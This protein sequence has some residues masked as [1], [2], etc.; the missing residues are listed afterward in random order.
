[1]AYF[2]V[3]DVN[4]VDTGTAT[5]DAGRSVTARTGNFT[6]MGASAYYPNVMSVLTGNGVAGTAPVAGDVI[7]TSDIHD[8]QNNTSLVYT[9][10]TQGITSVSANDTDVTQP[11]RAGN[12]AKE[13]D[14]RSS[15]GNFLGAMFFSGFSFKQGAEADISV[16]S[17]I[18]D[19]VVYAAKSNQSSFTY[20]SD[21]GSIIS[22]DTKVIFQDAGCSLIRAGG[23]SLF[24]FDNM[25]MEML[26]GTGSITN[27]TNGWFVVGGGKL[28]I[29]NTDLSIVSGTLIA[30]VGANVGG[31]DMIDVRIDN[32]KISTGT[33]FTTEVFASH[34]QR[35]LF[36]RCS[37]V[38]AEAEYQHHLHA[39]GGDVWDDA[40][41]YR[42]ED[43]AFTESNQKISY[44]IETNSDASLGF[45]LWLDFPMSQYVPLSTTSTL[46]FYI[47]CATALTDKDIYVTVGYTDSTNKNETNNVISAPA[48][49]GG[50]LDVLA[51]GTTLTTDATSTWTGALANLYK[52]VIDCPNGADCQPTIKIN[53][54]NPSTVLYIA[55]EYGI[56]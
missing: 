28:H 29:L 35:A 55:S 22:S 23:G 24:S 27:L 41:I 49:V 11:R 46:E 40:A 48:T 31:D 17:Q 14:T 56:S 32:C 5:G 53:V 42:N 54:T 33:L 37:D 12:F 19:S 18:R 4:G 44:K 43:A 34:N 16:N 2:Y 26:S 51:T 6:A 21:G 38:S 10:F 15:G 45:P 50:S 8:Y 7:I 25:T 30:N 39:F 3:K 36:T 9:G 1:M 13:T 20:S 52:I 47:T